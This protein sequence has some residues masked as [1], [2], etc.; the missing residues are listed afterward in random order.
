MYNIAYYVIVSY[1]S[2]GFWI[3]LF[4]RKYYNIKFNVEEILWAFFL[5]RVV[6]GRGKKYSCTYARSNNVSNFYVSTYVCDARNIYY[7]YLRYCVL[8][9]TLN[10]YLCG[11][12]R[13][14]T[15][16]SPYVLLGNLVLL[17]LKRIRLKSYIVKFDVGLRNS[18]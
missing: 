16:K 12:W 1:V 14:E 2:D 17:Y 6:C 18:I 8:S 11:Y 4:I 5:R 9:Y 10:I 13:T 3:K 7:T 15:K